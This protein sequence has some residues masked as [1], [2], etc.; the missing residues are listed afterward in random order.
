MSSCFEAGQPRAF[1]CSLVLYFS[2]GEAEWCKCVHIHRLPL[3]LKNFIG[4]MLGNV[5]K[6]L[7]IFCSLFSLHCFSSKIYLPYF[8]I[9][10]V[11]NSLERVGEGPSISW[12]F[13]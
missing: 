1:G 6:V 13:D 7:L 12:Y 10:S 8:F 5:R 4:Y 9:S 2:H 11:S 3:S